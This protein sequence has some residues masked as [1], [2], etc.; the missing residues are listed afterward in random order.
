MLP[1][2]SRI[3][4]DYRPIRV[5]PGFVGVDHWAGADAVHHPSHRWLGL[6]RGLV[7]GAHDGPHAAAQLMD[8]AQIPLDA[9]DRQAPCLPQRG[10][11]ADQVGAPVLRRPIVLGVCSGVDTLGRS[12]R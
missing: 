11:A 1:S 4:H 12:W 8:G 5:H 2:I 6:L 7:N 10:D 9:A 3:G